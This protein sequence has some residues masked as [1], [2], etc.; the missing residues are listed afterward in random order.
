MIGIRPGEKV[1]ELLVTEDESRHS[2]ETDDGYVILPEH[3]SWELG[4]VAG[5]TAASR[6]PLLVG[7]QRL[8][9]VGR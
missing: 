6:L 3:A 9:A 4:S 1:H 5:S 2:Y 8:V 7:R